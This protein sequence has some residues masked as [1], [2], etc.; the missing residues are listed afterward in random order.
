MTWRIGVCTK[1]GHLV[2]RRSPADYAICDNGHLPQ[3]V[4]LD[5]P[6][7]QED[8]KQVQRILQ[9]LRRQRK[10]LGKNVND[11]PPLTMES[12]TLVALWIGLQQIKKMSAVEVLDDL[13]KYGIQP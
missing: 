6:F 9:R 5:F 3:E 1:C 7:T 4:S 2:K 12:V 8:Q 11:P 10:R 13:Q